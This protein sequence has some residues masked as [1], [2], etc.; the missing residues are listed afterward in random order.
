MKCINVLRP[1]TYR[2]VEN[3][4]KRVRGMEADG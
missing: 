4:R 3:G 1:A 2:P